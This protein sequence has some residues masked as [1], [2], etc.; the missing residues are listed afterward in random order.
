[1]DTTLAGGGVAVVLAFCDGPLDLPLARDVGDGDRDADDLAGFV[2]RGLEGD[3]E[4]GAL[5]GLAWIGLRAFDVGDGFAGEGAAEIRLEVG[6]PD[7]KDVGDVASEVAGY[8]QIVDAREL[9]VDA[10]VAEVAVEEA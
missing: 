2:A 10:D 9:F 8:G 5:A 1:M 6:I 3:K 4:G 7:G